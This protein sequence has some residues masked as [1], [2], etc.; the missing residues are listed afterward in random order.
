MAL[1]VALPVGLMWGLFPNYGFWIGLLLGFGGGELLSLAAR[2][3]RGPEVQ[4]VGAAMVIVAFLLAAAVGRTLDGEF[5]EQM[6]FQTLM[7][8]AA[9]VLVL[10][11]QR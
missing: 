7:A 3:R 6:F 5:G 11:R 2:R 4:A 1:A 8:G 10:V 9:M